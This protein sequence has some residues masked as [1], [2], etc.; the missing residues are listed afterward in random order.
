MKIIAYKMRSISFMAKLDNNS[1]LGGEVDVDVVVES[2][3]DSD[4]YL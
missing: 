2:S 4:E 1:Q 3:C